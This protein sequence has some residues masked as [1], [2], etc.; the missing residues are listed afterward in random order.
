MLGADV[1]VGSLLSGGVDSTLTSIYASKVINKPLKTFSLSYGERINELPYALEVAHKIKSDH[2]THTVEDSLLKDLTTTIGYMDEPHADSSNVSQY[3]ISKLAHEKVKVALT[4]DGADE[5]FLGYG[6]Y[7]KHMQLPFFTKLYTRIFS[8]P[9]KEHLKLIEIFNQHERTK[10]LNQKANPIHIPE[11]VRN[12]PLDPIQKMNLWDILVYLPGQL[13]TKIDRTSM[14]NSL[15]VRSPFLD[16]A[17]AEYVF[18]LPTSYKLDGKHNNGKVIL[19]DILSEDMS[20]EFVYRRKQGFGAPIT[21]WLSRD[22][23]KTYLDTTLSKEAKVFQYVNKEE[24]AKFV[25]SYYQGDSTLS[26][27]V[28]VLLCLF[29]WF[30][31]HNIQ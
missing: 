5:L 26:Y 29:I 8:N 2:Y 17:L 1:E 14:M 12:A 11:E 18:S 4:G 15:E 22:E 7:W 9:F 28:W 13:L 21:E 23:I 31:T 27:R 25:H 20:P 3:L 24:V 30:D 16:T 10:L 6:W 19:K